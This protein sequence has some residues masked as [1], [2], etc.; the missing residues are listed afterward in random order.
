MSNWEATSRQWMIENADRYGSVFGL[1]LACI[2]SESTN[3]IL[4]DDRIDDW[5][6][7]MVDGKSV[8][9]ESVIHKMAVEVLGE[10]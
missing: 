9:Y 5:G 6:Y 4:D 1:T 2:F 7:M 10:D 3:G 8:G